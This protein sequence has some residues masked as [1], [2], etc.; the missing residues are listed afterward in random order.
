MYLGKDL[1]IVLDYE[2]PLQ[3]MTVESIARLWWYV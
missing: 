1:G 3:I 2:T